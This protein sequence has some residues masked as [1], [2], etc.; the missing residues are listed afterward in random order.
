MNR[1]LFH[2]PY[3]PYEPDSSINALYSGSRVGYRKKVH[4][5]HKVHATYMAR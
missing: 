5:V 3:E 1:A 2:V 4:K